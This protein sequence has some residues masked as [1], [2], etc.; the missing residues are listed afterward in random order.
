MKVPHRVI[1]IFSDMLTKA[2]LLDI[3]R[4]SEQGTD[5]LISTRS[6]IFKDGGLKPENM[7]LDQLLDFII[8]HPSVMRRPIIIDERKIQVGYDPDAIT[9]F[10]PKATKDLLELCEDCPLSADGMDEA[11]SRFLHSVNC[12]TECSGT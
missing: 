8:E 5:D 4:V 10:L 7:T 3:L 11:F 1:N 2:E 9:A 6:K 12:E